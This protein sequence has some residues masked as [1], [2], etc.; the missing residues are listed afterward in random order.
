M[1]S[2]FLHWKN[3]MNTKRVLYYS[4]FLLLKILFSVN[5]EIQC[6]LRNYDWYLDLKISFSQSRDWIY[7]FSQQESLRIIF[8]LKVWHGRLGVAS[9]AKKIAH[10]DNIV[11]IRGGLSVLSLPCA[12]LPALSIGRASKPTELLIFRKI[13]PATSDWLWFMSDNES[14][15]IRK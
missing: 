6:S 1:V 7:I 15:L 14:W 3:P 13:Q 11:R 8:L 5:L 12:G 4:N 10:L 2:F 9:A